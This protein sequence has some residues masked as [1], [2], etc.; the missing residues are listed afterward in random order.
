[1]QAARRAA[2]QLALL[3]PLREVRNALH[4]EVDVTDYQ[5]P[6]P[7]RRSSHA[8]RACV[9]PWSTFLA[10]CGHASRTRNHQGWVDDG[11]FYL[12]VALVAARR[13]VLDAGVA[14]LH[15]GV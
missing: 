12:L 14:Q 13:P 6:Q 3:H 4:R 7:R 5:Q 8:V 15:F 11:D 2:P 1:M 9:P 10:P